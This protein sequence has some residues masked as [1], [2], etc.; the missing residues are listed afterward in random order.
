MNVL[1][2]ADCLVNRS[3]WAKSRRS[4]PTFVHMS[5]SAAGQLELPPAGRV[6]SVLAE[7]PRAP[8]HWLA[9]VEHELRTRIVVYSRLSPQRLGQ[10][11]PLDSIEFKWLSESMD[12]HA[13]PP[14]LER[15]HHAI[16]TRIATEGGIVWLDGVEYLIQRQ[17]FD[18]FLAFTRSI[19]DEMNGTEWTLMLPFT[20]LSLNGTEV[21]HL[22]REAVPFEI[23]LQAPLP[24]LEEPLEHS[25]TPEPIEEEAA[26]ET[27]PEGPRAGALVMLS[28]IAQAAL[29]PAVLSRRKA[30]WEEMG[31]EVSELG[32]ALTLDSVAR[33][34][35]YIRVEEKVRRAVEC[36][37][38]I[39]MIEMRGHSVEA[40]KM[41]F[42]VLQL[43]GLTKVEERLDEILAGEL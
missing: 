7:D 14:S 17:G 6:F 13:L 34:E 28:T 11:L 32:H 25:P 35:V 42:R 30:Q 41:R 29:S 23:K 9:M 39:Q 15:I 1:S 2:I 20:P 8:L 22:R 10:H 40:V 19:A 3:E 37:R 33:H 27:I 5:A 24:D 4:S 21:A 12:P 38:R 16:S 18:A 36:E 31:L 26:P 43:T